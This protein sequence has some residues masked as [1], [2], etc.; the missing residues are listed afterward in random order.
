MPTRRQNLSELLIVLL[1]IVGMLAY[2]FSIALTG[3]E[4]FLNPNPA[5][6]YHYG[7]VPRATPPW[8]GIE[9]FALLFQNISIPT[10]FF[11][12]GYFLWRS[13]KEGRMHPAILVM[14]TITVVATL[15]EPLINWGMYLNFDPRVLHLPATMPWM[16]IAPNVEP[17]SCFYGYPY[18]FLLPALAAM[19]IYKRL[20]FR[21]APDAW[22]RRHPLLTLAL[23][24]WVTGMIFDF[25]VE[26]MVLRAGLYVYSQVWPA[27]SIDVGKAWQ[28]PALM[29]VPTIAISMAWCAVLLHRDEAGNTVVERIAQRLP[30]LR[31]WPTIGAIV[32]SSVLGCLSYSVYTGTFAAQRVLGLATSVAQPWPYEDSMIYDPDGLY[33][34]SGNPGPFF[35]DNG[36]RPLR[37]TNTKD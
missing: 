31:R 27:I 37:G 16:Q 18:Y 24:G 29:A 5:G 1:A 12:W 3:P 36:P 10:V 6:T 14:V 19:A 34:R 17:M 15:M 25:G 21:S 22:A 9:D 33:E 32:V 13:W 35:D 2:F 30:G 11:L 20:S 4:G 23:I 7:G 28:F 26:L 8:L